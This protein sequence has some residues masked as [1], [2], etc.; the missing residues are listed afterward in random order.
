MLSELFTSKA[1]IRVLL[2][3]FL[4]PG[5][6][7]YLRQL[8]GEFGLSPNALKEELD[9]LAG[10][11]Y[12]ERE[13]NGRSVYFRANTKHPFFPEIHS[14]VRKHLG[15]DKIIEQVISALGQI[16]AVY[17][18][19]DYAQGIDSGL[20]DLLIVGTPSRNLL[21]GSRRGV[22]Q[23]INRKIRYMIVSPE[24]FESDSSVFLQR[25]N[26]RVL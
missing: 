23:K 19:D 9:S 18:L 15:I 10:A 6:S 16:D 5:I 13:Q 25:P 3:L 21:E 22:E 1:R 2:K 4:N 12:L 20:I 8:S 11:G 24:E 14:I 26:C 7:C 17:L